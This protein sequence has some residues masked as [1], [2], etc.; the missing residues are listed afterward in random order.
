MNKLGIL[1]LLILSNMAQAQVPEDS[2]INP[3]REDLKEIEQVKNKT[4]TNY[5]VFVENGEIHV[6]EICDCYPKGI[7]LYAD[8]N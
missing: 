8:E 1:L 2:N 3:T 6:N 7:G 4:G 5:R